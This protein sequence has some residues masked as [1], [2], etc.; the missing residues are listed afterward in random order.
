MRKTLVVCIMALFA[1][2]IFSSSV[3][4]KTPN[5]T[6]NKSISEPITGTFI[7]WA[8]GREFEVKTAQ[9]PIVFYTTNGWY[10][11]H[12]IEGKTYKYFFI[13]NKYG[14]NLITQILK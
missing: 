1:V 9:G 5:N 8:D 6:T 12:L 10:M 14:Q 11:G 13:Q 2:G 7:G 4:A 3:S